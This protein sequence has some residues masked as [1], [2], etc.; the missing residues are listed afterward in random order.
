VV[1]IPKHER[2]NLSQFADDLAIY[3]TYTT[4]K[5]KNYLED[6]GIINNCCKKW[7]LK[8]NLTKT[9]HI[10]L[11][12]KTL[13]IKLNNTDIENIKCTKFMDEKLNLENHINNIKNKVI[14]IVSLIVKL[15]YKYNVNKKFYNKSTKH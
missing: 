11:G 3:T 14:P 10:N 12:T 8:I 4:K 5:R 6:Y 9:K 2:C 1:D 15:K 7:G 13:K